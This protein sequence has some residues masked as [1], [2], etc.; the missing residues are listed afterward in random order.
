MRAVTYQG[1]E[2]SLQWVYLIATFATV[3]LNVGT[4]RRVV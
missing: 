3:W 4:R 1:C 2:F